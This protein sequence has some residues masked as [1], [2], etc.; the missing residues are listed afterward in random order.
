MIPDL[1]LSE[2]VQACSTHGGRCADRRFKLPA[3]YT[4]L[5]ASDLPFGLLPDPG[6]EEEPPWAHVICRTCQGSTT[7]AKEN[8]A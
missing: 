5:T 3:M 1:V 4:P 2:T 8:H 7:D 6:Y